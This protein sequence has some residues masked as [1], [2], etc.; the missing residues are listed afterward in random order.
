MKPTS[1]TNKSKNILY[2]LAGLGGISLIILI[3]ELG[4]FLFAQFFNVPTPVFSLGFGPTLWAMQIGQTIF[5]IAL[6]PIGGYVEIDPELLAQQAYI[7]KMLIIFGG[8]LFNLI[9]AYCILLYYAMR[10]QFSLTS[11]INTVTPCSPAQYAGLQPADTI[12][13]CN[14]QLV[15][16]NA[17]LITNTVASSQG[18]TIV[19]TIE[20]NGKEQDVSVDLT[21]E[22]PLFGKGAGWLGIELEKKPQENLSMLNCFHKGHK[23]FTATTQDMGHVVASMVTKKDHQSVF[24]GPVGIISIIGKSLAIN[25]QYYWF[26][27]AVLSLNMG[28]FNILPLPFFDGGKALLFTIEAIIGTT[29]PATTVW[30]ISTVFLALFILFMATITMNDVKRL[31]KK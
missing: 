28:L 7:P 30:L 13:A 24:M 1:N 18:Q 31:W 8:I 23:K 11:T 6:L 21:A 20:R 4:H 27:L 16:T 9:F 5:K 2:I 10:N 3:H 19:L 14:G 25:P 26:I 15:G 29:I 22:H 12:I 17:D